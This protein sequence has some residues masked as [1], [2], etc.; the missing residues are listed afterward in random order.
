MFFRVILNDWFFSSDYSICSAHNNPTYC[1]SCKMVVPFKCLFILACVPPWPPRVIDY[2]SGNESGRRLDQSTCV[3]SQEKCSLPLVC[4]PW[5]D[6]L[7]THNSR[8]LCAAPLPSE[9]EAPEQ[10]SSLRPGIWSRCYGSMW[11]LQVRSPLVLCENSTVPSCAPLGLLSHSSGYAS[12]DT[13]LYLF[14]LSQRWY[15]LWL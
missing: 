10:L 15:N 2:V 14:T 9:E 12:E 7:S 3:I 5:R 8:W 4:H 1:F 11:F 13:A 6:R